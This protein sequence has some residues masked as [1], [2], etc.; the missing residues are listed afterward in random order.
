[1]FRSLTSDKEMTQGKV[2]ATICNVKLWT[3]INKQELSV[4]LRKAQ[5]VFHFLMFLLVF[6]FLCYKMSQDLYIHNVI[7]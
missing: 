6:Q 5:G 2:N 4:V 1:M 3:C 7:M